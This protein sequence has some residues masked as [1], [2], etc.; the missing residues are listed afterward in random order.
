METTIT[1]YLDGLLTASTVDHDVENEGVVEMFSFFLDLDGIFFPHDGREEIIDL[2]I[3]MKGI[4]DTL[5]IE[6]L[7]IKLYHHG[8]S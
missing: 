1:E 2:G 5:K 7:P 6:V 3:I 8:H 4:V